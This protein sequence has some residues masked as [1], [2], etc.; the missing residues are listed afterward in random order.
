MTE[1]TMTGSERVGPDSSRRAYAAD[2][3]YWIVSATWAQRA[4]SAWLMA[5]GRPAIGIDGVAGVQTLTALT[6]AGP[7]LPTPFLEPPG[8][9]SPFVGISKTLADRL[10]A[11]PLPAS[12]WPPSRPP[13]PTVSAGGAVLEEPVPAQPAPVPPSPE[14]VTVTIERTRTISTISPLV[15]VAAIAL[16][17]AAYLLFGKGSA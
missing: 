11:L 17:L 14:L 16:G 15:P 9:R 8:R 6:E 10:A 3:R 2:G 5:Q 1:Y 13:A 12:L 4:V 7:G